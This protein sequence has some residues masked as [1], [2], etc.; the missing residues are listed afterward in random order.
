MTELFISLTERKQ[1]LQS[2]SKAVEVF[3]SLDKNEELEGLKQEPSLNCT[4]NSSSHEPGETSA[5]NM[6]TMSVADLL[7][8]CQQMTCQN[9]S[10][11]N[12]DTSV[13][14]FKSQICEYQKNVQRAMDTKAVTTFDDT[15]YQT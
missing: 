11:I 7:I 8:F 6:I 3:P 12:N 2:H 15:N 9:T 13:N 5:P 10:N 1:S 4:I 14:D